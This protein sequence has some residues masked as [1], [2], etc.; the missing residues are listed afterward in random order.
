MSVVFAVKVYGISTASAGGDPE[1][2]QLEQ[3][4]M[5][6]NSVAQSFMSTD[7]VHSRGQRMFL[8][9]RQNSEKWTTSGPD[10]RPDDD[11]VVA[12]RRAGAWPQRAPAG[13][14]HAIGRQPPPPQPAAGAHVPQQYRVPSGPRPA[15]SI[16]VDAGPTASRHGQFAP[17]TAAAAAAGLYLRGQVPAAAPVGY[18]RPAGPPPGSAGH[19][20]GPVQVRTRSDSFGS[21]QAAPPRRPMPA[22]WS[23]QQQQQQHRGVVVEPPRGRR[24]SGGVGDLRPHHWPAPSQ[25]GYMQRQ[26]AVSGVYYGVSDL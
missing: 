22:D 12:D 15:R 26:A 9:R 7:N 3:K 18:L 6:A 10:S 16:S 1:R 8:L 24:L 17:R 19:P 5:L 13:Q 25:P 21:L 2:R 4:V 11:H 14:Q 23:Q 20:G